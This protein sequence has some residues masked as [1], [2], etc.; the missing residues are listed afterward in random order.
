M[1]ALW[2]A[3]WPMGRVVVLTMPPLLGACLRFVFAST[4]LMVWWLHAGGPKRMGRLS[5]RQ[6]GA[7]AMA[8]ATGIFGY[9]LFFMWGLQ[10]VPAGR[11]AMVIALNPAATLLL[12]AVFLRERLNAPILFGM[13]LAMVGA[14]T[15]LSVGEPWKLIQGGMGS[16]ELIVLGCVACW[17][18]Y[19]LIGRQLQSMDSLSITTMTALMGAAMLFV[20]SWVVEGP[21]AW[22]TLAQTPATTWLSIVGLALGATVLAYAWFLDGV[23]TLGA[24]AAAAFISLVPIF[25]V[26]FSSLWLGERIDLSLAVGGA[27]AV[28]GMLVMHWGRKR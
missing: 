1:A 7:L 16:G 24:S 26:L 14:V 18:I 4:L 17:A 10:H 22:A 21:R 25:G 27:F 15:A 6:W 9:A 3:S 11:A 13:A 19:T 8:S 2:G 5:L 12:A 28:V 23:K 20:A